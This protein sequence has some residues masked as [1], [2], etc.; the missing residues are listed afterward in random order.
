[1]VIFR[2]RWLRRSPVSR[3]LDIWENCRSDSKKTFL[4]AKSGG[5]IISMTSCLAKET[6]LKCRRTTV[7]ECGNRHLE[8][9]RWLL[10]Y[11]QL[12][13]DDAQFDRDALLS[14]CA[15]AC[16]NGHADVATWWRPFSTDSYR[17]RAHDNRAFGTP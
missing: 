11:F 17:R 14:V 16:Q 2:W 8:V 9:A 7:K 10:H 5:I 6:L 4:Q 13:A 12:I 15:K 3:H 1:M